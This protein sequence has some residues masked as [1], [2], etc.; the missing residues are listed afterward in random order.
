MR[1]SGGVD[2]TQCFFSFLT[3]YR[4]QHSHFI[5]KLPVEKVPLIYSKRIPDRR[6]LQ[7]DL[8]NTFINFPVEEIEQILELRERYAAIML[9]LFKPWRFLD[10]L[11]KTNFQKLPN[12]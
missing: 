1:E 10:D 3:G 8:G 2:S 4:L 5:R 7:E 6:R 11:G 9:I 12:C